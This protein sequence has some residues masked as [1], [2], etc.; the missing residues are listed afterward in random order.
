MK[1]LFKQRMF[2]WLDSFD[3]YNEYD[4]TIF[5]VEGRLSWGHRLIIYDQGGREVGEIKEEVLTF[6][7][8]FQMLIQGREIGMIQKE[9]SFFKPRFYLTCNDWEIQGNVM[10]WDY[11]VHSSERHIMHV[12]KQLFN[13]TDTYVMDIA[14]DEDALMCLMIVLAI[15]AAKCSRG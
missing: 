14:R 4:E 7:P 8:R 6:L 12:E 3:I 13:W 5:T 10:E 15:D 11:D 2:S 9:L 1:L